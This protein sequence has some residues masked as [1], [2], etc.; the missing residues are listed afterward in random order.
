M[1]HSYDGYLRFNT[2]LDNSGFEKGAENLEKSAK[3]RA[4]K[5]AAE[6]KKQGMSS[7]DAFK[8]AWSE[9]ERDSKNGTENVKN[10]ITSLGSAA[11]FGAKAIATG[12]TA[13]TGAI[14]AVSTYSLAAG[15]SFEAAMSTVAGTSQA[16]AADME[17]LS[18]KAKEMGATTKFTATESAQALNFMAQAGW[19]TQA[20]LEGLPGIMNLA[21]A[22]GEDLASVSDIVTDA[23]TAFG[24]QASESGHFADVLAQA[25][26]ASNTDV[27]KMGYTFKYVA[28]IAGALKYSIE[29]TAVAIGLMANAGLKGEMA[30]TQLRAVISRLVN[31]TKDSE[32]AMKALGLS[33][34]DSEGNMKDFAT[35]ISEIRSGMAGYSDDAKAS[36]AAMLG[37]QE[38]MSGLL[39]IA[40]ASETDF[41]TLTNSINNA[42]GAADKMAKTVNDNLKGDL[43]ILGSTAESVGIKIYEKFLT[44]MRSAAQ[45]ATDSLGNVL[46]SLNS[47]QLDKSV[48]KIAASAGNLLSKTAELAADSLPKLFNGFSYIIDH[49]KQVESVL[50]GAAAAVGIFKAKN[51]I[52]EI[53]KV[54]NKITA[55]VVA[56]TVAAK[57]SVVAQTGRT[58]AIGITTTAQVAQTAATGIATKAWIAFNASLAANPIG[59][60]ALAIGALTAGVVY[61]NQK[62]NEANLSMQDLA[63]STRDQVEAWNELKDSRMEN[64]NSQVSELES[65]KAMISELGNLTDANGKVGDNK[66]RVAYITEKINEILPDTIKWIDDETIAINGSIEALKKQIELKQAKILL[67]ELE[68]ESVDAREK[69]NETLSSMLEKETEIAKQEEELAALRIELSR[70]VS[71]TSISYLQ[72]QIAEKENQINETRAMFDTEKSLYEDQNRSIDLASKLS[73][74][75]QKGDFEEISRIMAEK[76][77]QLKAAGD[78][79]TEELT[80]Q[81]AE[82]QAL[83]DLLR[84][85]ESESSS[86]ATKEHIAQIK[87][88]LD[89][90]IAELQRRNPEI[91]QQIKN[92][93]ETVGLSYAEGLVTPNVLNKIKANSAAIGNI[94]RN[95]IVKALTGQATTTLDDYTKEASRRMDVLNKRISSASAATSA[96][97]AAQAAAKETAD[98]VAREAAKI[99]A[100]SLSGGGIS[101]PDTTSSKSSKEKQK[102]EAFEMGKVYVENIVDGIVKSKDDVQKSLTELSEDSI[103]S[104]KEKA[105][106]YKELGSLYIEKMEDGIKKRKENLIE[107]VKTLVDDQAEAFKEENED[108]K[109]LEKY[110]K[111]A[112]ALMDTYKKALEAG[113]D[114]A[115]NLLKTKIQDITDEAQKQYDDIIKQRDKLEQKLSGFGS[116]FTI[117]EEG[118]MQI[119]NINKQTDAL[120]RYES[121]LEQLKEKGIDSGLLNEIMNMG[122]EDATKFSEKLI[123]N[124]NMFDKVNEEWTLKQETI[125]AIAEKFYQDELT[126]LDESFT[127]KLDTALA[128]IPDQ[129]TNVGIDAIQGTI[130]GMNSKKDDA[131]QTAKDIADAIIKELKRATETASPSKRAA[132]EVGKPLTQGII[133]GMNDAYDPQ[134]LQAYTDKMMLDIGGSQA[135][136]AAQ[137][138]SYMSNSNSVSNNTV[139]NEAPMQNFFNFLNG[140]ADNVKQGLRESEFY[141][142]QR[143]WATGGV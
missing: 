137:S 5:L 33:I 78:S 67:D 128:T 75:I 7:S 98:A 77:L 52:E 13:V 133:K 35:I 120:K 82:M 79:T 108:K 139:Y 69:R 90:F 54:W 109:N 29:D 46:T 101:L 70:A 115:S 89:E 103:K 50:L 106:S 1:A 34:K 99:Q 53:A 111:A 20:M 32:Y 124:S 48:D 84:Q 41:Q 42:S 105:G 51:Q 3:S 113:A 80:K 39:A 91:A 59:W 81:I 110:T 27:G 60:A 93:G 100:S 9:I 135:K 56:E 49:G 92:T 36:L 62:Q 142:R 143:A 14:T 24:M 44:P 73:I 61:Y 55:A 86:Q 74:A 141:R 83:Y 132:R 126:T 140:N 63:K 104:A 127:Q 136:A 18:A 43:T 97:A 30:G 116:L 85:T 96:K 68:A 76:E 129:C 125:K 88:Q 37:G 16:S 28:P 58:T 130:D 11:E 10:S 45:S 19:Q 57:A 2:E 12:F 23:M 26:A 87:K 66:E 40:N 122:I 95:E 4:A 6:Y 107:K 118:N 15:S 31:P 65:T 71:E 117:D 119:E 112:N 102:K 22:S 94:T 25:A 114:D 138:V 38:A 8:Q 64:V 47:G 17:L 123:K 72:Q 121:A 134:E 131:V 21:A